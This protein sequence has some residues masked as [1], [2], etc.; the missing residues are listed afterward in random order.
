[1]VKYTSQFFCV[2][3]YE[4]LSEEVL[5]RIKFRNIFG[6]YVFHGVDQTLKQNS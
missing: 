1:M 5:P 6:V 2:Q 3:Q 4:L